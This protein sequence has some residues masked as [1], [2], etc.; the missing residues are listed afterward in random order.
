M[1]L[2]VITKNTV[3][4]KAPGFDG[5]QPCAQINPDIFFPE[6]DKNLYKNQREAKAICRTC[7]FVVPCLD[8]A[9]KSDVMG[10]WGATT[11]SERRRL[12][13]QIRNSK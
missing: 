4:T 13:R 9:L 8:Y 1:Q 7:E 2:G 12:R 3:G 11:Q 10:I 6:E 5:T